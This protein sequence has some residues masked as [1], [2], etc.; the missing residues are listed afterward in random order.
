M[1]FHLG[2]IHDGKS[3][4]ATKS[5][6]SVRFESVVETLSSFPSRKTVLDLA[7]QSGQV[8]ATA[9]LDERNSAVGCSA[10]AERVE[11]GSAQARPMDFF[12]FRLV[13]QVER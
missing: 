4:T 13:V 8:P 3:E 1:L 2:L 7:I 5:E 10:L 11:Q 6:S 9:P 12:A